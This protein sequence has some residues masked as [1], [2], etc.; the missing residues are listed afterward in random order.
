[1]FGPITVPY[2]AVMLYNVCKL[3]KGVEWSE[4][5]E[6]CELLTEAACEGGAGYWDDGPTGEW[7]NSGDHY[8]LTPNNDSSVHTYENEILY[9]DGTSI[10][11]IAYSEEEWCA[12]NSETPPTNIDECEIDGCEWIDDDLCVSLNF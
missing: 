4:D 10:Y 7:V 8:V 5:L 3:K 6:A 12:C 2:E 9:F 11:V 1:M